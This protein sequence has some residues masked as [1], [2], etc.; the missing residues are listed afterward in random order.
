MRKLSESIW[1]DI[2]D[3]S[4]GETTRKEDDVNLMDKEEFC[5]YLQQ[6][7]KMLNAPY[8]IIVDK[9]N[10]G[11]CVTVYKLKGD[12]YCYLHLS[13]FEGDKCIE[14][15]DLYNKHM[16]DLLYGT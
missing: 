1:S 15:T 5:G 13:N 11:V 12:R 6:N 10:D 3:R 16:R 9:D 4:T 2:Q 14:L 7:Y 8:D